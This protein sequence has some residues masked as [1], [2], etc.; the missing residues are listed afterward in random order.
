MERSGRSLMAGKP[1]PM[2]KVKHLFRL[3]CQDHSIKAIAH[4]IGFSKNTVKLYLNKLEAVNVGPQE[5]LQLEDRHWKI[6]FMQA[7]SLIKI[8]GICIWR[9]NWNI[10]AYS[11]GRL[12][13]EVK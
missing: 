13:M 9:V 7:I 11:L 3:H 12:V 4:T 1:R 5:L 8:Q 6:S 2:S 10:F